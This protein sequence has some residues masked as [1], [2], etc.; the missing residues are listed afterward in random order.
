[1]RQ[2]PEQNNEKRGHL[3]ELE[4]ETKMLPRFEYVKPDRLE[5]AL[6]FLDMHS[7]E[8]R[9][10]AGGT[11]LL[12]KMREGKTRPL[13]VVDLSGIREFGGVEL[14]SETIS[15][16][17]LATIREV[18]E[19]P[20]I[21]DKAPM[22]SAALK[23]FA[24]WQIK[25]MATLG[26]NLCNASPASDLA[27]PLLALSSKLRF[28]SLRGERIIPIDDFF[29]GPGE[30]AIRQ[31]EILAEILIPTPKSKLWAFNKLGKR[32]A[33]VL[34]IVN[35]AAA[36]E[37]SQDRCEDLHLALGSVAPKPVR[38]KGV[39]NYLKNA[40]LSDKQIWEASKKVVNDID[41]ISDLRASAEYRK[42]MSVKLTEKSIKDAM[43][44]GKT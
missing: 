6:S 29:L 28:L 36:M 32:S 30:T 18:E 10:I 37:I 38:A 44:R 24:F 19:S 23:E 27:T 34:S 40:A 8:S 17:P 2:N 11:D 31:D 9:I 41:P 26:G 35:V 43:D 21:R 12:V 14:K 22:L 20:L 3:P 4:K 1:V 15:I 39:E 25:N 42:E 7:N 33:H 13:W 5:E 16:G